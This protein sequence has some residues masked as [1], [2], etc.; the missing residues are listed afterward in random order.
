MEKRPL[1]AGDFKQ[2]QMS[3][4]IGII[5]A[6]TAWRWNNF[7]H[8]RIFTQAGQ[9]GAKRRRGEGRKGE[10]AKEGGTP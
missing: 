2:R 7:P 6:V 1:V 3:E 9:R 5:S 4:K 8:Q 10:W